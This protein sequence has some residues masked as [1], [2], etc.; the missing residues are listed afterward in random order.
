MKS[1]FYSLTI[2]F[3]FPLFSSCGGAELSKENLQGH[4]QV[5][6]FDS[7]VELSPLIIESAREIALTT[8]YDFKGETLIEKYNTPGYEDEV[9]GTWELDQKRSV[10][11]FRFVSYMGDET[12]KELRVTEFTG[13]QM[14]WIEDMGELGYNEYVLEKE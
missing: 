4:W 5:I 14:S 11:L 2:L 12:S 1:L 10:I 7:N 13:S 6:Q 8:T 3:V 9:S